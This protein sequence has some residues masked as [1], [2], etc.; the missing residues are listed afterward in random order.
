MSNTKPLT[1]EKQS[2]THNN[3]TVAA[4]RASSNTTT[5]TTTNPINTTVNNTA[6]EHK[7]APAPSPAPSPSPS[8]SVSQT[9]AGSSRSII[10]KGASYPLPLEK[11]MN[12]AI[13]N[14]IN[15]DKPIM[16]DYWIDSLLGKAVIGINDSKEK[17]LVKNSEEYTSTIKKVFNIDNTDII[18]ESENSLYIVTKNI[19]IKSIQ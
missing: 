18:C 8:S 15:N 13:I 11:T 17:F 6:V 7:P 12:A 2:V 4:P 5:T 1:T 16:L 19:K 3:A 9:N 10:F 14:A